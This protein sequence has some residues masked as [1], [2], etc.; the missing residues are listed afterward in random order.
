MSPVYNRGIDAREESVTLEC[1]L[2]NHY[3][4]YVIC[5]H[6]VEGGWVVDIAYGKIGER[7]KAE[8]LKGF[9]VP[10]DFGKAETSF[11]LQLNAKTSSRRGDDQ[12]HRVRNFL[13]HTELRQAFEGLRVDP[14]EV[15]VLNATVYKKKLAGRTPAT[16]RSR[17]APAAP[18]SSP[19]PVAPPP[20]V[21][22]DFS[23]QVTPPSLPA[24]PGERER[25]ARPEESVFDIVRVV[26]RVRRLG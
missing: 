1:T 25:A 4:Q 7:L 26:A 2:A 6:E 18:P 5:L 11:Y 24:E 3:K 13:P 19:P 16:R 20:E 8:P 17:R 22:V 12:Y 14:D 9:D 23:V 15:E 10:Q 21:R